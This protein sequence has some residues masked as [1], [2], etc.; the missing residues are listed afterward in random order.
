MASWPSSSAGTAVVV[1][2]HRLHTSCCRWPAYHCACAPAASLS[3]G[4]LA[5]DHF[6]RLGL[7]DAAAYGLRHPDMAAPAAG[8]RR[9]CRSERLAGRGADVPPT[10]PRSGASA[11]SMPRF[12]CGAV[13]V[14]EGPNGAGKTT[15]AKV[16][17][18]ATR[19]SRRGA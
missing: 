6:A 10:R 4:A 1:S 8:R 5:G 16:L 7:E 12:A 18:G 15:L 19:G 11:T 14:I 9:R 3:G 13:T 17:C 2:E